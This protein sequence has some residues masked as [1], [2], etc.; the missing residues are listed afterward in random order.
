MPRPRHEDRIQVVFVDQA[1]HVNV[2]K[3]QARTGAPVTEQTPLGVFKF[4][5]LLEQ[6]VVAQVDHA[7]RQVVA[8]TPVGVDVFDFVGRQWRDLRSTH[9]IYPL[10]DL[11]WR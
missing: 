1:I 2:G 8:G 3:G 10:Y 5:R 4:E 7:C 9:V 11:K 6:R